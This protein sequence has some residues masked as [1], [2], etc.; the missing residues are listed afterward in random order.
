M[1][2]TDMA[3]GAAGFIL[4]CVIQALFING[5]KESM[6]E[7]NVLYF[8]DQWLRKLPDWFNKPMGI[9]V[10]CMASVWGAVTYWPGVLMMFGWSWREVPLFILNVGVLI[11]LNFF[12]YKKI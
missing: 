11:F 4:M 10:K 5:V 3:M 1:T 6:K 9:C 8:Y 12:F 2:M 7:N